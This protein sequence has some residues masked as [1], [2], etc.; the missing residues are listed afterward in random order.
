MVSKNLADALQEVGYEKLSP[1]ENTENTIFDFAKN[2]TRIVI[3]GTEKKAEITSIILHVLRFHGIETDFVTGENYNNAHLTTEND[4]IIIEGKPNTNIENLCA[5]IA[6]V[7]GINKNEDPEIYKNFINKITSGGVLVYNEQ[8]PT[9]SQIAENSENYFRK[10][11]YQKPNTKHIN[12]IFHLETELGNIPLQITD[13][14]LVYHLEGARYICQQL[15]VLE[16]GFYESI[17]S[18]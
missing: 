11:P 9:L 3:T 16:E 4:F 14:E 1:N 8:H 15:G 7:S 6:L 12:N 13:T 2:K 5:N 17:M 18:F 10:F